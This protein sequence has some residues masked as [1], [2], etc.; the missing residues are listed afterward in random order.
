ME[1]LAASSLATADGVKRHVSALRSACRRSASWRGAARYCGAIAIRG[2]MAASR[3]GTRR[4]LQ[5]QPCRGEAGQEC[6]S[7]A[8]LSRLRFGPS[9]RTQQRDTLCAHT[10]AAPRELRKLGSRGCCAV[11]ARRTLLT[12]RRVPIEKRAQRT[13]P[14]LAAAACVAIKLGSPRRSAH[15]KTRTSGAC[16]GE[17]R[18]AAASSVPQLAS[19]L[20]C[21]HAVM[22]P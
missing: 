20:L 14:V 21:S 4:A 13:G 2:D 5:Q 11:G 19:C 7:S 6:A 10:A 9:Q 8:S 18:A 22:R 15:I 12:P 3:S 1:A 16:S 17:K